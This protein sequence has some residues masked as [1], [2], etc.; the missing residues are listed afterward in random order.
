MDNR[1]D[2]ISKI[3]PNG[4]ELMTAIRKAYIDLDNVLRHFTGNH[5]NPLD[6]AA[7]RTLA[8]ARTHLET[9]LQFAIKTLCLQYE[10]KE[11]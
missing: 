5:A 1:L 2:F 6:A 10:I 11:V 7:N 3:E 9:S 8:L 4:I